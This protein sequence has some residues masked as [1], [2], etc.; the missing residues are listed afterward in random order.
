MNAEYVLEF[1]LQGD[2]VCVMQYMLR[3]VLQCVLQGVLH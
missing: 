1:V 2:A 3:C